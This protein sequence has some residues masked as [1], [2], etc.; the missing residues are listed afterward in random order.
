MSWGSHSQRGIEHKHEENGLGVW[1]RPP[2]VGIRVVRMVFINQE[3]LTS[4][5]EDRHCREPSSYTAI[6]RSSSNK[7]FDASGHPG[8]RTTKAP[9]NI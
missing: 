6:A 9:K 1:S 5:T 7:Q 4:V 2:I 3:E 8:A